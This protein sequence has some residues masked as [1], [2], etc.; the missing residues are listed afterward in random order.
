MVRIKA[1][2]FALMLMSITAVILTCAAGSLAHVLPGFSMAAENEYLQLYLN[3]EL[4]EFAVVDKAS[5]DIW[6]SNPPDRQ[7]KETVVGGTNKLRLNSQLTLTYYV[8]NQQRQMDSYNDS[9]L[10]GQYEIRPIPNGFRVNYDIGK[11]WLDTDYMPLII[12]EERF[13]AL[14]DR[15]ESEADQKFLRKQYALF[16]LEEGFQDTDEFS[17]LGVDL[18]S[19]LGDYGFKVGE[20]FRANDKRRLL[21]EYLV[22]LRDGQGYDALG[23][24][25][26]EDI[27]PA[28]GTPTLM[29]R[30][31]VM[32]WDRDRVMQMFKEY[33]Y[34]PEDVAHD[35]LMYGATPPY[36]NLRNFQVSVE[37]TIDG[38]SLVARI[39]GESVVWPEKVYD[40]VEDD[41][42][43]YPLTQISL[44]SYFGASDRD[45]EGYILL[46]DGSGALVYANNGKANVT[47]YTRS[48]YGRDLAA[49]P[50]AEYS[51]S[52]K[53]QIYLPV[54]GLKDGDKAFFAIIEEGDAMASVQATVSG[55]RDSFNK[56][57]C[58]FD[59]IPQARVYMESE[60]ALIHL[61]TLSLNMYQSRPYRGD[62]TVRYHFL[63]GDDADYA[64]MA[65]LYRDYLVERYQL[66]RV[67]AA[68]DLPMIL[69]IV[70]SIDVTKP[71]W[72]IPANVV[73]PLTTYAQAEAILSDML[74]KG[75]SSIAVRY[76]GWLK[77][78]IN[79]V[80]PTKVE[81]ERKVGSGAEL[82]SLT[83]FIQDN[84]LE[85]FP[86]VSFT[87]MRRNRAFDRFLGFLHSSRFLNRRQAHLNVHN[88]ATYQP[89]EQ[90]RIPLISPAQ[91]G[92]LL[93]SFMDDYEN[94]GIKGLSA[95]SFG[96]QLFSDFRV[97][98]ADL[99][100]RQ[101]AQSI[102]ARQ[103]KSVAGRGTEL[104][105][106]RANAYLFPYIKYIVDAPM[107]AHGTEIIDGSV[108]FYQMVI[109]GYLGYGG[110]AA[111]LADQASRPYLLKMLETGALPLFTVAA[112]STAE[113]KHTNFDYLYS[114]TYD[115]LSNDILQLY[116]E[117]KE[118][119]AGLWHL[120][121]VDHDCLSPNV[122]ITEYEDGTAIIVNY[123]REDVEVLDRIIPA[124]D[125]LV[126]KSQSRW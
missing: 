11:K 90:R 23:Q 71:V 88:I 110:R 51:S 39:P 22:L 101:Q 10:I 58:S 49:G 115:H 9:V 30:W 76:L 28:F 95:G 114:L 94:W 35:H 19:L 92:A 54:F 37:Y 5:G 50:I 1:A 103:A 25:T 73:V 79:H 75:V 43:S 21:Q 111:N 70:G 96:Y 78:G 60:G 120:P 77:G 99:V 18:P 67:E 66:K 14:L 27:S 87:E 123:N 93:Q 89:I 24:V 55:M 119:L 26:Q 33:G 125:Y 108:P 42:V 80:Y 48:V 36:P 3:E 17:I 117:A 69:E 2:V 105:M 45:A 65:R 38:P 112:A 72:G 52:L 15:M 109:S 126:I 100:D 91:Y 118:V 32:Q 68:G 8:S 7:E 122:F 82:Q 61:R 81:L 121:I 124:E 106:E 44:L 83:Q 4:V 57:W 6:F 47:P 46:P 63:S 102:M 16:T 59:F 98:P 20:S 84:A 40:P 74:E 31:N 107:Y 104:M 116:Q 97:N 12:T 86:D 29:F 64:A 56:A 62:M 53:D 41:N 34:T 113:V 13:N 85:L